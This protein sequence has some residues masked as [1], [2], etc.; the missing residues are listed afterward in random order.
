MR[1][2]WEKTL[3]D[4]RKI[5][6]AALR[7]VDPLTMME[8]CLSIEA[9]QLLIRTE[10]DQVRFDLADFE[11]I[12][13]MGMGKASARMALGVEKLLG[14]RL[15]GGLVVVKEGYAEKLARLTV[16]ETSHPLPDRRS[17]RVG[18]DLSAMGQ[19]LG[20]RALVLVL[21]SG[22]GSALV[23]A[24]QSGISLEDKMI[25]TGLLM[26]RGATIQEIN[27]VRKHLSKIKGGRLAKTLAP[28]TVVT[29]IIS[30]VIGDDLDAIAS[31][32]TVADPTTFADCLAIIGRYAIE[33]KIPLAV[34]KLLR[35]GAQGRAP[36]TPKP[37][38]TVF[39]RVKTLLIGTN[40]RALAAGEARAKELGYASMVLTSRLTGEARE[41]A[42]FIL[43]IG[44]D[45]ASAG[46]PLKRPACVLLGGET[47]VT[48]RGNGRGGRNQE[49]A[50]AFLAALKRSPAHGRGLLLFSVATDGSDGPTDAAGAFASSGLLERARLAGLE[51]EPYLSNN[52]SYG[53][54]NRCGGLIRTGPTRT[55]VCDIHILLVP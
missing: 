21:L 3:D 4:A 43:G 24:P 29:L 41:A 2:N 32:P 18:E 53:F 55:N 48:L 35:Q 52:D 13:V 12:I 51:P 49:L 38:D 33:G 15:S 9:G 5:F 22:G 19:D 16:V 7:N 8:R 50:L 46:F 44:K 1:I 27:C 42:L 45:I 14:D 17:V 39:D 11:R 23:C 28:A 37:G 20:E 25:T 6:D 26:A 30:D 36:E 31:G 54:F 10:Y 34:M 40:R 47:T